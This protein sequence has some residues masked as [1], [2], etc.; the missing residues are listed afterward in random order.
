MYS[1]GGPIVMVQVENEYA[2][3]ADYVGE[4]S[5]HDPLYLEWLR[6]LII[7]VG[8]DELLF[9][10]DGGWDLPKYLNPE[11]GLALD[12]VLWTVNFKDKANVYLKVII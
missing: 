9:T 10:C 1:E 6:D 12:G 2:G 7:D 3:Y 5:S 8:V 4:D 11:L